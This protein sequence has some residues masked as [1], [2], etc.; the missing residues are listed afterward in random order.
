M[1]ESCVIFFSSVF[2]ICSIKGFYLWKCEFYRP[3]IRNLTF[4]WLQIEHKM[5]KG[6]WC[7]NF[8]AWH[9][10]QTFWTLP[11]YLLLLLSLVTKA[12]FISILWLA[13]ELWQFSFIKD[14]PEIQISEIAACILSNIWRVRWVR[15]TKFGRNISKKLLN[16]RVTAFTVS[17]L[18]KEN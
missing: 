6:Q 9:H 8:L 10:R 12:V 4:G 14:W 17:E 18:L 16:T 11:C 2:R 7:H 15:V 3:C 13:L 5:E 1:Y